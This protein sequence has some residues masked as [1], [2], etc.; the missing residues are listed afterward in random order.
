MGLYFSAGT[1]DKMSRLTHCGPVLVLTYW[2]FEDALVQTYTLP[3]VK[4]IKNAIGEGREI[5]LVTLENNISRSEI[6]AVKGLA[7]VYNYKL[8]YYNFG[9]IAILYWSIEILHLYKL[10]RNKSINTIHAWCTPAGAIGYIL[11]KI[12]GIPLIIDSFEPHAE[13]MVENKTW[14]KFG[15]AYR[16]LFGLE[17]RQAFHASYLI[18]ASSHMENYSRKKYG[19]LNKIFFVKPACVNFEKFIGRDDKR[20]LRSELGLPPST[21]MIYAGKFGGIYFDKQIISFAKTLLNHTFP[22]LHFLILTSTPKEKIYAW[23]AEVSFPLDRVH[24]KFVS[25]DEVP[26]YMA[27][28][29]F[30]LTP[31]KPVPSKL[32]CTPIKN[33]EY[34]ACGLPVV[35]SKNISDDSD[36][37]FE[38]KIGAICDFNS[39]ESQRNAGRIIKELLDDPDQLSLRNRIRELAMINRNF[40]IAKNLYYNIYAQESLNTVKASPP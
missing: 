6:K 22:D 37:I 25:H 29:D 36:L 40:D 21:I 2:S 26:R 24:L 19:I 39:I 14:S 30:A 28:S 5:Y 1:E 31:V 20:T 8:K 23:C 32:C 18:A 15:I 4:I 38:N 3:Y 11:S 33:G 9:L 10:C 13:A 35:I 17:R 16:L 7:D 27:A 34:W 12:S